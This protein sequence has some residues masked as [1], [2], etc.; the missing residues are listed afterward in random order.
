[1]MVLPFHHTYGLTS[2]SFSSFISPQ[3]YLI[4]S[5]WETRR[6]LDLIQKCVLTRPNHTYL[7]PIHVPYPSPITHTHTESLSLGSRI[8]AA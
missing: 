7:N 5:K 1:M 6:A 2:C 4:M 8:V 3:T